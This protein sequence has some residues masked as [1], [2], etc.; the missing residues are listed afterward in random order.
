MQRSPVKT[1]RFLRWCAEIQEKYWILNLLLVKLSAVWFSLI[2]GFFGDSL[3]LVVSNPTTGAKKLSSLGII[4]TFAILALIILGEASKKYMQYMTPP[5][6]EIGAYN[7]L[8]SLRSNINAFCNSKYRQLLTNL[9]N[10]NKKRQVDKRVSCGPIETVDL[11]AHEMEKCLVSLLDEGNPQA[12]DVFVGMIYQLPIENKIEDKGDA[13]YWGIKDEK[14]LKLNELLDDTK[15]RK[16]TLKHLLDEKGNY[17]FF[18]SKATAYNKEIYVIDDLD[19]CLDPENKENPQP[20]GSIACYKGS[21][22][23][24]DVVYINYAIMITTYSSKFT[25]DESGDKV[26]SVQ[27]NIRECIIPDFETRIRNEICS[28][29]LESLHQ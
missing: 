20:Q 15:K 7:L 29:Y 16:S 14:G 18:N 26:S 10:E 5:R 6:F 24:N 12:K 21:V 13:W 11:L 22:K 19:I 23:R 1:N 25:E 28:F 27:H 3:Q 4:L 17:V 9:E 8:N 2:I